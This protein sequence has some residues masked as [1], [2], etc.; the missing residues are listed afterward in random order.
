MNLEQEALVWI[1]F[2]SGAALIFLIFFMAREIKITKPK[3]K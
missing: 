1:Y 3:N 2:W